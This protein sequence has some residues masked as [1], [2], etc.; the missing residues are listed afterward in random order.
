MIANRFS[1]LTPTPSSV[2]EIANQ[3]FFL[4]IYTDHGPAVAQKEQFLRINVLKLRVTI[5]ML[6][7]SQPFGVGLERVVGFLQ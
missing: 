6:R 3:L 5:R 2:L 1:G 4:G 7:S